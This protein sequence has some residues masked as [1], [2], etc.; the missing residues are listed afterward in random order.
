[1]GRSF[2][3]WNVTIN[4]GERGDRRRRTLKWSKSLLKEGIPDPVQSAREKEK[5]ET[6]SVSET[7]DSCYRGGGGMGKS[8][9]CGRVTKHL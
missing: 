1:M 7:L 9:D 4:V 2:D 8:G 5:I 6:G 3:R